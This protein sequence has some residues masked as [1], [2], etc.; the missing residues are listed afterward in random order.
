MTKEEIKIAILKSLS[1]KKIHPLHDAILDEACENVAHN[2]APKNTLLISAMTSFL[3]S[4]KILAFFI[5]GIIESLDGEQV[6][7]IYRKQKFIL[8]KHDPILN[9]T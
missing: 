7:L 8:K 4:M 1:I 2:D 9:Y 3:F 5:N 6:T